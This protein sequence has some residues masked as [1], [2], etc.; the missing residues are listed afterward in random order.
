MILKV[1]LT[2]INRMYAGEPNIDLPYTL[3]D[4]RTILL[5]STKFNK[6]H[7][8]KGIL[9]SETVSRLRTEGLDVRLTDEN[10]TVISWELR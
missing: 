4:V 10:H 3:D 5:T 1:A 9:P 2:K 7:T 8:F 6:T